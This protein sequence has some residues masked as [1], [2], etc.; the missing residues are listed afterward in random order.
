VREEGEVL[1]S[2]A[3]F[4]G[5]VFSVTRD[6]VRE[7]GGIEI[8]REVVRH[9]GSAVILPRRDDGR[10]LLVRQF[11]LPARRSI[12]ELAAGRR[13]PGETPLRAARRELEEET[14]LTAERWK[15]L[16]E[17]Y[18]SPGYV[19]ERM[20]LFLAEGLRKGQA[21]PEDDERIRKRWFTLDQLGALVRS[22]GL[23]DAK[24]LIGYF[25][26]SVSKHKAEK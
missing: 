6:R 8:T 20:W 4:K 10:V 2:T 5:R 9:A 12:W 1:E 14:G 7:P 22:G 21:R 18:P 19:D 24:T 26:I 17:F 16:G 13:D 23:Q 25:L 3:V 11:R 15:L